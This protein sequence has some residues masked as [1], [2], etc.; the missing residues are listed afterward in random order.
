MSNAEQISTEFRTPVATVNDPLEP[1]LQRLSI[2]E[3]SLLLVG[4]GSG[5]AEEKACGWA[6]ILIDQQTRGRRVSYGAVNKGSINFAETMPYVQLLSWFDQHHGKERLQNLG[7]LN[8]HIVTDSQIVAKWGTAAMTPGSPVPR[9]YGA[10][11]SAMR[12]FRSLGYVCTFHWAPRMS[13]N[14]NWAS[15]LIAGLARV[16]MVQLPSESASSDMTIAQRA[17]E[18]IGQ[19]DFHSPSGAPLDVYSLD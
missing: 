12:Y 2:I 7:S 5:N 3:Y 17:A 14:L 18:T 4:D 1:L 10:Y 9:K 6:G 19:L 16:A 13:T 8:V 15:D 11:W